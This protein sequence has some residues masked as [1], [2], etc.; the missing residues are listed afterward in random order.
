MRRVIGFVLAGL[1]V[2]LIAVAILLPTWVAARWSSSRST[3]TRPPSL[4]ASNAS[5]FSAAT[6]KEQTGVTIQATYTIKGEP[7][8]A[9]PR[10]PCGT[11][12][13]ASTT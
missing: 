2:F 9:T 6:L 1:G 5:Y 10:P 3:R 4:R 7:P 12:P 8:R 11:S 13:A